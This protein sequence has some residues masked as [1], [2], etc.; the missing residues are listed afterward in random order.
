MSLDDYTIIGPLTYRGKKD[1]QSVT[2]TRHYI[3]G[4]MSADCWWL[5]SPASWWCLRHTSSL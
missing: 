1:C 4:L 3:D 5:P 2:C